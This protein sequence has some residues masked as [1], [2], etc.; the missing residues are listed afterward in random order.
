MESTN[1]A[2]RHDV[3]TMRTMPGLAF[4]DNL[5]IKLKYF[6]RVSQPSYALPDQ[7]SF[8]YVKEK[9]ATV[10]TSKIVCQYMSQQEI[11]GKIRLCFVSADIENNVL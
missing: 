5:S 3:T 10:P 2:L 1:F 4:Q 9:H 8:Y 6:I 11:N 7:V